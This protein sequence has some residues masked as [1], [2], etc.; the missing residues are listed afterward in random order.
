MHLGEVLV[1]PKTKIRWHGEERRGAARGT[2]THRP[3]HRASGSST[4]E[5][6][7]RTSSGS[8]SQNQRSPCHVPSYAVLSFPLLYS[9]MLP[10]LTQGRVGPP[11]GISGKARVGHGDPGQVR[12]SSSEVGARRRGQ[13]GETGVGQGRKVKLTDMCM[14]ECM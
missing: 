11:V 7:C 1:Y 13:L 8:Y 14:Y 5:S 12:R 4:G 3:M 10:P 9:R 2:D 6:W